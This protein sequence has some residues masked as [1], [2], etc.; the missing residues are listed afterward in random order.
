MRILVVGAGAIGGYYGARL[1]QAGA[2]VTFLVRPRRGA[3][4]AANGLNVY[5]ELGNFSGPVATISREELKPNYDLVLLSCKS[6]D[7]ENTLQDIAPALSDA[8]TILPLLNGLA[9]YDR[10]DQMFGRAR[11]LG[12]VAYIAVMLEPDGSIRH[13]GDTDV[14][15][16]GARSD[17]AI[18]VAQT[19]HALIRQSSGTR[20]LSANVDEVLWN[21]WVMLASGAVMTCLM[22]GT[23]GDILATDDGLGLMVQTMAECRAVANAEGIQFS[24]DD[25]QRLEA[26]LLDRQS[27]WAA[28]MMRDIS[29]DAPRIEAQ[30]IVGDMLV[31]AERHDLQTPLLRVAYCHLQVYQRRHN[32]LGAR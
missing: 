19:F 25:V 9:V 16:T 28:S 15:I 6:Y 21:K 8:T 29:Q 2:D 32:T 7:L 27:T 18:R 20:S 1:L 22:R 13:F 3:Y 23:V 11:V 17:N 24:T 5:S 30:A 12:G 26:R 14:V 31:R 10:L 4:L